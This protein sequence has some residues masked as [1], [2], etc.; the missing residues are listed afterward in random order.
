MARYKI[1]IKVISECE[2]L[3]EADSVE[4]AV[5]KATD[6]NQKEIAGTNEV[7][8]KEAIGVSLIEETV[9]EQELPS[10]D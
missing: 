3:V 9:V 10:S 1:K 2:V 5:Y 6:E 4:V 8:S 7:I